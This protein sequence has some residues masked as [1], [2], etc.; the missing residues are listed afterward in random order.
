MASIFDINRPVMYAD[1]SGR[2]LSSPLT[3]NN[4]IPQGIDMS[5]TPEAGNLDS[6]LAQ[7]SGGGMSSP[8]VNNA[9]LPSQI[10]E[11]LGAKQP[12][13]PSKTQDILG[14]RFDT[15]PTDTGGMGGLAGLAGMLGGT[16]DY[17]DYLQS[18]ISSLHGKYSSAADYATQ[19]VNDQLKQISALSGVQKDLAQAEAY[20]KGLGGRGGTTMAMYQLLKQQYPEADDMT[21]I[22]LAQNK[23]SQDLT[24]DPATGK[25]TPMTG[26]PA[27]S[28]Q[29]KAAESAGAA[30]GTA[31][32][33]ATASLPNAQVQV[34]ESQKLI[35]ELKSHP[36]KTFGVATYMPVIRGSDRMGFETR[37]GQLNG[38][39]FLQAFDTLRGGGQIS[40]VEGEKAT[41]AITRA[42]NAT[43]EAEFNAA[44]DDLSFILNKGLD[45]MNTRSSMTPDVTTGQLPAQQSFNQNKSAAVETPESI[46]Q[47][48]RDGKISREQAKQQLQQAHGFK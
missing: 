16:P 14:S 23:I 18:A 15:A 26:A 35:D 41:Q 7:Y 28:G 5:G 20:S 17:N 27:A 22:R 40:N 31:S 42:T 21:L 2:Q 47:A 32:G 30:V 29:M 3:W 4:G 9:R 39:S 24:I 6:L 19:G 44:L 13:P 8:P 33:T 11:W 43:N 48:Y 36:G 45:S 34:A 37:L 25:V 38:R 46:R 10:P 12:D 1:Q